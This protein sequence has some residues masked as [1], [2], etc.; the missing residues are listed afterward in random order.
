MLFQPIKWVCCKWDTFYNSDL[1]FCSFHN[2]VS[3]LLSPHF[4]CFWAEYFHGV[5]AR[6]THYEKCAHF[7][8]CRL[9]IYAHSIVIIILRLCRGCPDICRFQIAFAENKLPNVVEV[10][11]HGIW[12][13][14]I[15]CISLSLS[16]RTK[17][18]VKSSLLSPSAV[19]Y[20]AMGKLCS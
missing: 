8:M 15:V 10:R 11:W 20:V 18:L 2:K 1:K 9:A 13:I 19:A 16:P 17:S 7:N 5:R 12:S 3:K 6:H 14:C 4:R